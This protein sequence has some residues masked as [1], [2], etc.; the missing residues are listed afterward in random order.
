M[1]KWLTNACW[2][3]LAYAPKTLKEK[4]GNCALILYKTNGQR[5]VFIVYYA[6]F[7]LSTETLI[8]LIFTANL[9]GG[10]N[11]V[12]F[13]SLLINRAIHTTL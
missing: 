11:V 4:T 3:W 7:P 1:A 9:V 10:A 5:A 6:P 8:T 2:R 12:C 13:V